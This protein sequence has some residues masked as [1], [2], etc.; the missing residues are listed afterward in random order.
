VTD[1]P[2]LT[3]A[4]AAAYLQR[5]RRFILN[6]VK[7]GRLRAARVGLRKEVMTRREW[8]DAWVEAKAAPVAAFMPPRGG[9]R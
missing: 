4:Q 8:C 7:H 3:T 6:E 9:G 5:G 2:W 1:S